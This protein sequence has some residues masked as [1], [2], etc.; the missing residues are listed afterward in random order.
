GSDEF[1]AWSPDGSVI[2]FD[3]DRADAG[4]SDLYTV[5]T[6]G[7]H[8]LRLTTDGTGAI[9]PACR[10]TPVPGPATS[11][12]PP[13]ITGTAAFHH[14][15]AVASDGTWGGY[16]SPTFTYEWQSCSGT[17]ASPTGCA[18]ISGAHDRTYM[19]PAGSE[20]KVL[21][22]KVTGTNDGV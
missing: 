19:I 21:R 16:P 15:L 6:D 2:A 9:A 8:V 7:S 3:S 13:V 4:V 22:L 17:A 11:I 20:G 12:S 14:Q 18:A 1:P 10:P 5:R